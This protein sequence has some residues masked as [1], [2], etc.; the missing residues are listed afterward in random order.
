MTL[1][2][3]TAEDEITVHLTSFYKSVKLLINVS[4]SECNFF[5]FGLG[6]STGRSSSGSSRHPTVPIRHDPVSHG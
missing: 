6:G 3:L 4:D 5:I 2:I 1:E